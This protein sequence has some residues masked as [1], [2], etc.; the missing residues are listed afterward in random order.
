M[1][2]SSNSSTTTTTSSCPKAMAATSN[3]VWQGDNPVEF[4]LPLLILQIC[5]VILVTRSLAVLLKPLRQPRVIAEI[6]GGV[7]LGPSA[8]GRITTYK[9]KIFPK[10]SLT[11]LETVADL[12][13]LLFLF[14]V[15]LE[16]DLAA[17]RRTGKHALSIAA[18][19]ITLPFIAGVGV[20]VVLH[21]TI[22]SDSKFAPF[23]VFMGVALSITAFPV[24]ARILAERRLLMT[25]VGQMAMSAAAV[26]DVVAWVLL[27][28]AVAL[29]GSGKSPLVALWVLLCGVAYVAF[30]FTVVKP[31]MV[32]IARQA[33]ESE[34]VN[35]TYV[36]M[37]LA[38]VLVAGFVTD[39]IGIHSI[40]GA[41]VF[42]LVIPKD[43]HFAGLLTEKIEDLVTILLL[44]LYFAVSGLKTNIGSIHGAQ[45]GGL[46]VLVIT[47]ACG[48][49][50]IGTFLVAYLSKMG[51]RKSLTLGFLMNTKGLVELIVLNI[52]K[53]RKVLNDETFAI[54]V[55][56]ALFTTFITTPMIMWLYKP[57]RNPVPYT[58]RT[59]YAPNEKV[60][61]SELRLL[62]CV[63]GMPNVHA[64][65]NLV[66]AV[67]GTRRRP[68]HIYILQLLHLSE[69]PSSIMKVQRV[70][71]EGRPFWDNQHPSCDDASIMVAFEAFGQLSKVTVRPMTAISRLDDMHEDICITA[72]DKRAAVIIL[73]FHKHVRTMN[74]EVWD[75]HSS[76]LRHVTQRVLQHAPCSV[77]ILVD[78]GI[79]M[80]SY[81]SSSVNQNVTV[82]FYGGPDDRE[83]LAFGY[84]VAEHP[85]VKLTVYRF[86]Y[87][88]PPED[89]VAVAM[90]PVQIL[91]REGSGLNRLSMSSKHSAGLEAF[92][93]MAND[94]DWELESQL[95]E[96]C[97]ALAKG[98]KAGAGDNSPL[99]IMYEEK[100]VPGPLEAAL[101]VGRMEGWSLVIVGRGRRPARLISALLCGP[102][103]EYPE[104]GPVG[105]AL[106][107]APLSEVHCSVLVVQQYDPMLAQ[108]V[109]VSSKV[110]HMSS[111]KARG[112]LNPNLVNV[113]PGTPLP[114]QNSA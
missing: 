26:N 108:E 43:G 93:S 95:D 4:A 45:A 60:A 1:A 78:C 35:E 105:C 18:A 104:L 20:S 51:W 44:P 10:Q 59:L 110:M 63:Q 79:G 29:S 111:P 109:R 76:G 6:I 32:K 24:L 64:I 8:L 71:R 30:M 99:S 5:L 107:K 103:M 87:V 48:G 57:A 49:K 92:M 89:H 69:R 83:A 11:L 84:R 80:T 70:R 22:S 54:M 90:P 37:T 98:I 102:Q 61:D 74:G 21:Q 58:R 38:A 33:T 42:G 106:T 75:G 53:D 100:E 91:G 72:E 85:G 81:P 73:P 3:G 9:E 40:F 16:L 66:E 113:V 23:L 86:V 65:I 77:G 12:G 114:P 96:E 7:L 17:L 62:A 13:L 112:L 55:I 101:E 52:G 46:L 67:R 41:F 82:L 15:G 14:L 25:D 94:V 34:P 56:M 19:G 97:L 50:I 28:L 39:A 88:D 2:D 68:L 31:L 27:A 36:A 47:T